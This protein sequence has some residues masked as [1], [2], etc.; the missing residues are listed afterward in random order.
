MQQRRKTAPG[1]LQSQRVEGFIIM[2]K[3]TRDAGAPG[4]APEEK[5]EFSLIPHATLETLYVN[6]LK[7][8]VLES[9]LR[10]QGTRD[11]GWDAVKAASPAVLA[12]LC[13]DDLVAS[14]DEIPMAR[15][16]R[17]EKASAVV[18]QREPREEEEKLLLHAVGT[19]LASHTKKDGKLVT[20]LWR[21]PTLPIWQ[22][23]LEMVRAHTLPVI[24]VSPESEP[25]KD[26]RDLTPGTE[27]PRIVV[28]GYDAVAVYRVAHEAIDR[29]RRNRGATLIECATFRVH[30]QRGRHGDAVANMERYL[31][32]KEMLRRGMR[33]EIEQEFVGELR[34]QLRTARQRA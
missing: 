5:T 25:V 13:K 32:G 31:R 14:A 10:R 8:R 20:I 9:R 19:A 11:E 16:L 29:A 12:D 23:A 15:V 28:D 26:K 7:G 30:G 27:L 3:E 24:L 18:Q 1:H 22:D 17:G 6:L 2:K 34:P 33:R 21:D 4:G